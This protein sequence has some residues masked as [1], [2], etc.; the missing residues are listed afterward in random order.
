MILSPICLVLNCQIQQ[1]NQ[2]LPMHTHLAGFGNDV[3][4]FSVTLASLNTSVMMSV[5][6]K[7]NALEG[8]TTTGTHF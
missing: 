1:L 5:T 3:T 2:K 8:C 4:S 7:A 6:T